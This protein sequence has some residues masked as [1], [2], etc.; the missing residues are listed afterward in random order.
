MIHNLVIQEVKAQFVTAMSYAVED[1]CPTFSE[2]I[3]AVK[4]IISMINW[5]NV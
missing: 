5:L 4:S 3:D 1:E 2:A